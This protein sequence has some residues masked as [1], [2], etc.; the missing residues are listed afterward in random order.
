MITYLESNANS[1][2]QK[3]LTNYKW[4][5]QSFIAELAIF[6]ESKNEDA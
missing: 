5:Y 4:G 1:F 6:S 2:V 3:S